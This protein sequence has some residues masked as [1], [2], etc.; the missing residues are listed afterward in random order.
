MFM[1]KLIFSICVLLA[2]LHVAAGQQSTGAEEDEWTKMMMSLQ[3]KPSAIEDYDVNDMVTRA[4][5][6]QL[7]YMVSMLNLLPESALSDLLTV[8]CR[9]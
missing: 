2:T 8:P 4:D 5:Q 6:Y 1:K 7:N 3:E 9:T